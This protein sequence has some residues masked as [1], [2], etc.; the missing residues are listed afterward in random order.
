ME[1]KSPNDEIGLGLFYWH[2]S[3]RTWVAVLATTASSLPTCI[4]ISEGMV[5]VATNC[6]PSSISLPQLV[7]VNFCGVSA[8]FIF[9]NMLT[10]LLLCTD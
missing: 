1:L 3:K 5:I 7:Q 4:F 6:S 2:C 9:S 8:F 10:P